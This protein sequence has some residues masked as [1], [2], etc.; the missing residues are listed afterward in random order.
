MQSSPFEISPFRT[1]ASAVLWFVAVAAPCFWTP[2]PHGLW[3]Q[4]TSGRFGRMR[5]SAVNS[6]VARNTGANGAGVYLDGA[7]NDGEFNRTENIAQ[8]AL[9]LWHRG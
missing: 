9:H 7:P 5:H 2:L 1:G 4:Q 8:L 3:F 6:R